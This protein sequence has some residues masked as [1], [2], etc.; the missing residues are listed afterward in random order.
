MKTVT[1]TLCTPTGFQ[2]YV[3]VEVTNYNKDSIS[4]SKREE[5]EA[6]DEVTVTDFTSN[7]PY[8]IEESLTGPKSLIK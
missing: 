8:M 6:T 7:L 5:A 2:R 1:I 3:E 4:F